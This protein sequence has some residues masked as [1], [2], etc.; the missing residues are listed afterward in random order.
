M[1][2]GSDPAKRATPPVL[3]CPTQLPKLD[4]DDICSKPS[5]LGRMGGAYAS[6]RTLSGRGSIDQDATRA[7]HEQAIQGRRE[8][9]TCGGL[10]P[11]TID[12]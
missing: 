2:L 6:R 1:D 9:P 5:A 3:R 7:F 10:S 11:G 4:P 12:A 8:L